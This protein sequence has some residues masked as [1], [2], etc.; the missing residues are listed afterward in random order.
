MNDKQIKKQTMKEWAK[1]QMVIIA[2]DWPKVTIF[3]KKEDAE[4]VSKQRIYYGKT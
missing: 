2:R 4:A 3:R 1:E